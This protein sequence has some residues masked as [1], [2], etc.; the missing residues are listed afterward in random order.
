MFSVLLG[1]PLIGAAVC[2]L[3]TKRRV[4]EGATLITATITFVTSLWLARVV[5]EQSLLASPKGLFFVDALS[6][7]VIIVVAGSFLSTAIYSL[8][9]LGRLIQLGT[10][11][12][13]QLRLYY[14]LLNVFLFTMLFV[15]VSN[16]LGFL[17][18][19]TEATTLATAFLVAF[20]EKE[21]S[22]EA[23]WKYVII[24]SVGIALALFGV[25][26]TYFASSS[27]VGSSANALHWSVLMSVAKKLDPSVLK[28]AFIFILVGFGTKAG[29]APMHTWKPDVYG[30]APA[31]ISGLMAAALVNVAL[32][33]L[34]RFYILVHK[35][36]GDAYASNLLLALG[37]FSMALAVPFMLVQKDFKRLLS[38]S[39]VEH[40][41]II[42]F[43]LGLATPL[44]YFG[45]LLHMLNNSIAKLLLFFSTG[46]M[47]I[48]YNSKIIRRISGAMHVMPVTATMFILGVFAIT[49]W[50]P[51]GVFVSELTILTAGFASGNVWMSVFFIGVITTIFLGFLYYASSMVWGEPYTKKE[52]AESNTMTQILFATLLLLLLILGIAMP[53]A[54]SEFILKAAKVIEG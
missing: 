54:V 6:A 19:G 24:C 13:K 7:F 41:G 46:N 12:I 52:R 20:Y 5:S 25:I 51:F 22:L 45:A 29:L 40:V 8:E 27:V 53:S 35:A 43:A 11:S 16:N 47:R 28:V 30:E 23:A 14:S 48:A 42:T 3:N 36:L 38:Y 39:S 31:P 17:W 15:L 37:L 2:G 34:L 9:Y 49:G 18:I 33:S 10:V 50:P 21:H 44:A 1:I 26:L 32:Y 4:L